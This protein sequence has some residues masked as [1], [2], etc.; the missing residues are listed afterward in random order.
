[1][2]EGLDKLS[3]AVLGWFAARARSAAITLFSAV[4]LA[5][6]AQ[7][8]RSLVAA[9]ILRI[10]WAVA[11]LRSLFRSEFVGF[12]GKWWLCRACFVRL[13]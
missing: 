9:P 12:E 8:L 5:L 6:V 4:V 11:V 2:Q 13:E 1:M 3:S 7:D 10:D